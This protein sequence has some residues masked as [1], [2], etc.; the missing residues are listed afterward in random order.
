MNN[1]ISAVIYTRVST[2]EQ[3]QGG[4]LKNQ[5]E[6]CLK[7]AQDIGYNISQVKI[8]EDA[9][10]GTKLQRTGLQEALEFCKENN[11]KH[12]LMHKIDRFT[13]G[14][15]TDFYK[16]KK[17][18][19]NDNVELRDTQ[20]IIGDV[21]YIP[22]V[23]KQDFRDYSWAKIDPTEQMQHMVAEQ[24]KQE[25]KTIL[26]RTI[27]QEYRY[28]SQGYYMG[29]TPYGYRSKTIQKRKYL[30]PDPE[31]AS[32]VEKMF[33]LALQG[34]TTTQ[35][36]SELNSLG[37]KTRQN[38]PLRKTAVAYYLKRTT[39]CGVMMNKWTSYTPLP[40]KGEAIVSVDVWNQVNSRWGRKLT[41][42][43][44]GTY[45]FEEDGKKRRYNSDDP[46]TY[47]LK[48]AL[49]CEHCGK[50]PKTSASTSK[51]GKKHPA[52][53]CER[54]H[55]R[56]SMNAK[57][58]TEALESL[59]EEQRLQGVILS[60][61]T[62]MI[63]DLWENKLQELNQ[64]KKLR[65]EV[66][67]AR[68]K[69]CE[70]IAMKM[71]KVD[72]TSLMKTWEEQHKKIEKDIAEMEVQ[73][74]EPSKFDSK[75]F[76]KLQKITEKIVEHPAKLLLNGLNKEQIRVLLPLVFATAPTI[77]QLKGGTPEWSVFMQA[78]QPSDEEIDDWQA[79]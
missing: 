70:N 8:F 31:E 74:K 64:D 12:F 51:S 67:Q 50:H 17:R 58:A 52:Y 61:M 20:N 43:T 76:H 41:S 6:Q 45:T 1:N 68:K 15:A 27:P 7:Y 73:Q 66:I 35:I 56:T 30:V 47:P 63:Q 10:T 24:A 3:A 28:A 57:K 36:A 46:S 13:R 22:A 54:E 26:Q 5:R 44:D 60:I 39:Y 21:S 78:K 55:K 77:A 23:G 29:E 69:E 62:H 53:H 38:N 65:D 79:R 9:F 14:G 34:K 75:D 11:V 42:H 16:L 37:F 48:Y 4:S 40:L 2:K 71:L 49:V 72:S 59:L 33:Q 19:E 25:R 18:L 32:Y